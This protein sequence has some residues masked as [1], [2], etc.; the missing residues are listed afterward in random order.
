MAHYVRK[1]K[2]ARIMKYGSQYV[3]E[4]SG[5]HGWIPQ[6]GYTNWTRALGIYNGLSHRE[7][8]KGHRFVD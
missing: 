6:S 7:A 8:G 4:A 2:W 3:V 1:N 5:P